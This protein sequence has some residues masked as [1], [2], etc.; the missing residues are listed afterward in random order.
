[1]YDSP[2]QCSVVVAIAVAA[3][4]A[5][6]AAPAFAQNVLQ[7]TLD[8][9]SQKTPQANTADVQRALADGSAIVVDSRKHVEYVAGH[10]AGARNA[11]SIDEMLKIVSGDRSKA[12]I[13]YCNGQNCQA[14]RNLSGELVAA[15]F[16]NV[17]RYQLGIPMWRTLNG[18]VEIELEGILR[19]FGV[20]RTA[21]Y[22][23]ARSSEEFSRGSLP[24]THNIPIDDTS[25]V[26]LG[27]KA[28]A[29]QNDF[30]TRIIL[31]GRDGA[32]ARKLADAVGK[33]PYQ[34]VSYF[35]GTFEALAAA[36]KTQ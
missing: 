2:R 27:E 21:V 18:P 10:I 31:F 30:N 8:E 7:A 16:S 4:L 35:P 32:Q 12:I 14:S 26:V 11:S 5:V 6:I 24:G 29:L 19:I 17:R 33:T 34:N 1:M 22:V 15:G 28:P 13:L 36:L 9:S 23:D 25:R 20:D 3:V